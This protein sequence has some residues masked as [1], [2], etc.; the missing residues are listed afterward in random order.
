MFL[1]LAL[2]GGCSRTEEPQPEP[3]AVPASPGGEATTNPPAPVSGPPRLTKIGEFDQPTYLTSPP[4]DKRLF[5]V[6]KEGKVVLLKD[7]KAQTPDFL[8]ISDS[9][10]NG[11]ERGLFSMAFAPDY[12][13]SGLAYV[14]YTNTDGDTRVDEYRVNSAGDRLDRNSRREIL[15]VEQPFANH[16]GGLI[17]F[18]P[19]GMLI[20]GLGDGGSGG[21]PGNRAQNL[22][23]LLGKFV[24]IDPGKPS[25]GKAYGIP[26]D[27][28][29]RDRPGVRPEIWA[30]GLRNPWRWSFD[31]Q[32][33]DFFVGDVG[34]NSIE[35]ISFVPPGAQAGANYGWPKF[36][37][38]KAFKDVRID[39]S[40]LITPVVEYATGGGTCAV[41]A[42]GVYRGS[43]DSL[44]GIYL[45]GDFCEGVIKGFRIQ[46]G[47]ATAE[48]TFRDLQVPNLA[49]FGTDSAGEMY[50]TSLEG[51]VFKITG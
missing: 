47:K 46:N 45:Y 6:E 22:G 32:T 38:T 33:R 51:S 49:S 23:T 5:V 30:Y 7:G 17:A 27:N 21:D 20:L 43:V 50:A 10:S 36:E 34:E 44:R 39:E 11:G 35:E 14:S 25:D 26:A 15:A 12:A 16:N 1:V 42:G 41:T 29:F 13:S 4:N 8:D 40:R 3:G 31:P 37:G 28:P 9:V 2:L 48:Q 24:R 19:E 18:D